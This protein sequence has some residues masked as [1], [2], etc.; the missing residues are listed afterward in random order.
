MVWAIWFMV[1]AV[2]AW[3]WRERGRIFTQALGLV[4]G[5]WAATLVIGAALGNTDS[6]QPLASLNSS[7]NAN[8]VGPMS[9]TANNANDS[10]NNN[11]NNVAEHSTNNSALA[12]NTSL[13]ISTLAELDQITANSP[14]VLV[15]VTA[16]W[17]IECRIMDKALFATP[18]AQLAGWQVV[19]LDITDT[20]PE[21]KAIL[22]RYRLFGPPAL[23]YYQDGKLVAQQV[24]ETKR[25]DFVDMLTRL[26]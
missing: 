1:V 4:A 8:V 17:C 18:P 15:D 9:T 16:E 22:E 5:V 12:N 10:L 3:Q 20:T 2:W 7:G 6:L 19:K 14:K 25:A 26:Q 11:P 24:G 13:K 21:S 23:L